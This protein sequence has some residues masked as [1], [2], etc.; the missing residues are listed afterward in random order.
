M[1]GPLTGADE[2]PG[3]STINVKNVNA[4]PLGG[5]EVGDPEATTIN[6]KKRRQWS[7]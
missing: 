3:V 1:A 5:T 4:G 2:D 6:I 7:L